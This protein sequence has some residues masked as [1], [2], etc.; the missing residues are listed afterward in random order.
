MRR[1]ISKPIWS[2]SAVVLF[3]ALGYVS[4]SMCARGCEVQTAQK[5]TAGFVDCREVVC[6]DWSPSLGPRQFFG[7]S[8]EV[9]QMPS[10]EFPSYSRGLPPD[11]PILN[12]KQAKTTVPFLVRVQWSWTTHKLRGGLGYDWHFCVLGRVVAHESTDLGAI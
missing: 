3:L 10:S 9:R 2:L 8:T 7:A 11:A 1:W 6:I 5:L 4:N 12:L